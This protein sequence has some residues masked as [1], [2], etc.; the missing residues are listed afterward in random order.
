MQTRTLYHLLVALR[1]VVSCAQSSLPDLRRFPYRY[2]KCLIVLLYCN[3][4]NCSNGHVTHRANGFFETCGITSRLGDWFHSTLLSHTECPPG[5]HLG[6]L[7]PLP[8][9]RPFCGLQQIIIVFIVLSKNN[10]HVTFL[11]SFNGE[12]K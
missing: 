3:N 9:S 8:P 2:R 5:V 10:V 6:P 1:L 4:E 12:G 7:T 11:F